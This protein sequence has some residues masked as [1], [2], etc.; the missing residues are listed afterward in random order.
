[1]FFK[2]EKG[3]KE[4][5]K[6]ITTDDT[7][8]ITCPKCKKGKLRPFLVTDRYDRI[9]KFDLSVFLKKETLDTS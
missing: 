2:S 9:L 4:C 8:G 7:D 3:F 5:A 6:V 1:E